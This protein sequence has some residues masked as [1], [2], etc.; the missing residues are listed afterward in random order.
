M[1]SMTTQTPGPG[2]WWLVF[3]DNSD[4]AGALAYHDHSDDRG[5]AANYTIGASNDCQTRSFS[6]CS[7]EISS[8]P[9][10]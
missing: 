2:A 8:P 3:L 5:A 6:N 4:Q 7:A 9:V 1:S 10:W